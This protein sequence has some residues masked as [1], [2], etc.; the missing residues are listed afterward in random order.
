MKHN[1]D[2]KYDL[3]LGQIKE[4]EIA[5]IFTNKKIEVKTDYLAQKTGNIAI[6][7]QSRGKPSGISITE[8]DYY[9]YFLPLANFSNIILILEIDELKRLSRLYFQKGKT[10]KMGDENSSIA[11]LIPIDKLFEAR[12][13]AFYEIGSNSNEQTKENQ[14]RNTK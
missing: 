8:A 13:N 6:E 3:L 9:A 14:S 2:F 4:K 12:E 11:V 5:D 10:T 1:G 7:Y